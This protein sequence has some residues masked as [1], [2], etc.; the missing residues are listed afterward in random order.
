MSNPPRRPLHRRVPVAAWAT[1]FWCVAT[2]S[3]LRGYT[4]LP[5]MP[6]GSPP[7]PL[8]SRGLIA[9]GIVV[10][11]VGCW[12]LSRR[13]LAGFTL[14]T[15]G[16]V[17]IIAALS[18]S[19]DAPQVDAPFY[20]LALD[21][22]FGFVVATRPA[23]EWFVA[24][25]AAVALVPVTTWSGRSAIDVNAAFWLTYG[26]MPALVVGLIGYSV[27]QARRYAAQLTEHAAAQAVAAERLRISRELHD[28]VAHSVGVIA[29]QAGAAARIVGT[30]PAAAREAMTAVEATGR[31][32][33]SGLR[34]MLA[35]LR[36]PSVAPLYPVPG[37]ADLDD[38]AATTTAAG[39]RVDLR[40]RG[41]GVVPPDVDVS[42]YRIIQES[43]AN[44]IRH[45][46]TGSCE[47]LV[48]HRG[49]E[50]AIEVTDRGPGADWGPAAD[51]ADDRLRADHADNRPGADHADR[52]AGAERGRG[53]GFGLVGMRE[54]V[55]LLRGTFAAGPQPGGGFRVAVRLPL[56]G[57]AESG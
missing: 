25:P 23:W 50:L 26:V 54:R 17:A 43:L 22:A 41:S 19:R 55:A 52:G 57:A 9:L 38:L 53:A 1:G 40:R 10:A 29:L 46:R 31:E 39:V 24:A 37:L 8:W 13:V 30:R 12:L 3:A 14:L 48:D 36:E 32:T 45:A 42:A 49:G 51:R 56:T 2:F 34:R 35:T 20:L 18:Q 6:T 33:L 5:G 47:V 11:P 16:T 4:G 28:M 7:L 44:V 27:R 15:A 21:I